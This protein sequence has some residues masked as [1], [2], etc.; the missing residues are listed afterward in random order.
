M[1]RVIVF[2]GL[3]IIEITAVVF[4][5]YCLGMMLSKW[6]WWCEFM[7]FDDTGYWMIGFVSILEFGASVVVCALF[8]LVLY[9]NWK[10]AG[11]II[12]K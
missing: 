12:N 9:E 5:P 3:K 1:K 2:I 10:W 7:L 6:G 11:R 4:T 8:G